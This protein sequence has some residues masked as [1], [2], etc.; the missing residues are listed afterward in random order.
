MECITATEGHYPLFDVA[1]FGDELLQG[2]NEGIR[3]AQ[4]LSDGFLFGE[5]RKSNN[6]LSQ[7]RPI[8]FG[9]PATNRHRFG[10]L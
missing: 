8:N 1:F 6:I 10:I 9:H 2:F 5:R 3:I 4:G 7:L